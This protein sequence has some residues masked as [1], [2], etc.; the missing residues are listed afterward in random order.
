M[1]HKRCV[2]GDVVL[3]SAA[4]VETALNSDPSPGHSVPWAALQCADVVVAHCV[5]RGGSTR[6]LIAVD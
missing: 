3:C 2:A 5:N 1:L 4:Q 6:V